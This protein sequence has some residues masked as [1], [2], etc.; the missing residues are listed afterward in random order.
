VSPVASL[1][2]PSSICTSATFDLVDTSKCKNVRRLSF[3]NIF[4]LPESWSRQRLSIQR[5][6]SE[7]PSYLVEELQLDFEDPG[8][9]CRFDTNY[10]GVLATI[11]AGPKFA[12]LWRVSIRSRLTP[13]RT[14]H[15]RRVILDWDEARISIIRGPFSEFSKRGLIEFHL[16]GRKED[17]PEGNDFEGDDF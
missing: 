7:F 10:W 16:D 4:F 5:L 2:D 14:Y 15:R 12:C 8:G 3:C 13:A 17:E 11:L 6:L 1:A 9:I